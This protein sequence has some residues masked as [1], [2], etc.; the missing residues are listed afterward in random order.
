MPYYNLG[1]YPGE[2]GQ[3][4]AAIAHY[5]KALEIKPDYAEAHNNLGAIMAR[6][7]QIDAAI[8]HFQKALEIKPD[9]AEC[10]R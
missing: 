10:P 6:R 3:V 1:C 8:A 2:R 4:D 7:G 9:Y 5:Q